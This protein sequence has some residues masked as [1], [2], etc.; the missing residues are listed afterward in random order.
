MRDLPIVGGNRLPA[1]PNVSCVL[2]AREEGGEAV[3]HLIEL[4]T[5]AITVA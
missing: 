1:L 2:V 4:A 5:E 3:R